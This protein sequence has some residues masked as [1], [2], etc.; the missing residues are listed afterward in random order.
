M[1][2]DVSVLVLQLSISK[3]QVVKMQ[4]ERK[5][6]YDYDTLRLKF[7]NDNKIFEKYKDFFI[8]LDETLDKS[9]IVSKNNETLL[10]LYLLH[11]APAIGARLNKMSFATTLQS[12]QW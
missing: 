7:E 1:I 10:S 4:I 6:T 12:S 3:K 8:L 9:F 5:L 2:S 11:Q